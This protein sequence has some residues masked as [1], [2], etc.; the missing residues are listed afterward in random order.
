MNWL[1]PLYKSHLIVLVLTFCF[2]PKGWTFLINRFLKRQRLELRRDR[3][4]ARHCHCSRDGLLL[5]L[6]LMMLLVASH[7]IGTCDQLLIISWGLYPSKAGGIYTKWEVNKTHPKASWDSSR[8]IAELLHFCARWVW[9]YHTLTLRISKN[10]KDLS[11]LLGF[12]M[13]FLCFDK[14]HALSSMPGEI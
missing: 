2:V 3:F 10:I 14:H 1:I 11:A 8:P 4:F 7:M 6:L 5:L 9:V 13:V 12:P